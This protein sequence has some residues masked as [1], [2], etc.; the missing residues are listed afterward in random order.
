MPTTYKTFFI[1]ALAISGFPLLSGFF[2]KDEILWKA[3][4]DGAPWMW[5]IAALAAGITAFY[6]FRLVSLTFEGKERF[7]H[8]HLHPH[9]A[10]KTMLIPLIV[11]A[12]LSVVG[13]FIGVPHVLGGAVGLH[14][15][16]EEF[17]APVF[18]PANAKLLLPVHD[19]VGL[20][21]GLMLTSV[22]IGL[23]GIWFGRY[24]YIRKP[25]IA[26][27]VSR[28]FS[29]AYR[30]LWNKY[31]VDELYDGVV[32]NPIRRISESFLWKIVDVRIIDDALNMSAKFVEATANIFRRIQ[33][34]VVQSYAVVFVA[35][36]LFI[37]GYLMIR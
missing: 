18:A 2:S 15:Y 37:I 25:A 30:I 4:A 28:K 6:M 13:G 22:A 19:S 10:P 36:I 23:F 14:N 11:L 17:L 8:H 9:E 32:V 29:A 1:G 21:L 12:V 5:L 31:Y 3:F 34:G 24:V 35:G 20:E 16:F 33:T 26:E 27:N 7:D